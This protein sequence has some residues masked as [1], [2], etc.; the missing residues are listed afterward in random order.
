MTARKPVPQ[1]S[2]AEFAAQLRKLSREDLATMVRF[3]RGWAPDGT[4]AALACAE[5]IQQLMAEQRAARC[6]S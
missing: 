2:D 6:P 3:L 1:M 5:R 4:E